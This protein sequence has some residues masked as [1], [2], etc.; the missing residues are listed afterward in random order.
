MPADGRPP[1]SLKRA[2]TASRALGGCEYCVMNNIAFSLSVERPAG[3]NVNQ[4]ASGSPFRPRHSSPPSRFA[5]PNRG[6]RVSGRDRLS[7]LRPASLN[8]GG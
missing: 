8:R 2:M 3:S 7:N 1:V 4:P 5:L 6:D